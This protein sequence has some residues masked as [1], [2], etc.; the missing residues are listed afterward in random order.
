[1][2]TYVGKVLDLMFYVLLLNNLHPG[3]FAIMVMLSSR[4][5]LN[6]TTGSAKF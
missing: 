5:Q 1:M 3:S 4:I 2:S 6:S